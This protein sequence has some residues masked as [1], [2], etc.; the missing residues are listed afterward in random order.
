MPKLVTSCC[1]Y[2]NVSTRVQCGNIA[3]RWPWLSHKRVAQVG[4]H[5]LRL[6]LNILRCLCAH[7]PCVTAFNLTRFSLQLTELFQSNG[8]FHLPIL[9]THS[10]LHMRSFR[11]ALSRTGKCLVFQ[12]LSV[13]V[14]HTVL[15]IFCISLTMNYRSYRSFI[16]YFW[17]VCH[18]TCSQQ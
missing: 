5:Q 12:L 17:N 2:H 4:Q 16:C 1:D 14:T 10:T 8:A 3:S 6:F 18:S 9:S 13:S 11:Y 7:L 15:H